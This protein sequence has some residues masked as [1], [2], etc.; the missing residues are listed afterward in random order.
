MEEKNKSVARLDNV[1]AVRD[2]LRQ[3]WQRDTHDTR[4][5]DAAIASI[6]AGHKEGTA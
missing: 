1:R 5:L 6:E 2:D 3:A 4:R